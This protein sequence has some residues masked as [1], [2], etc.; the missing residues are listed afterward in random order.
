M[1]VIVL[2]VYDSLS[3]YY[4]DSEIS[5]FED[6]CGPFLCLFLF[7]FIVFTF[8]FLFNRL[9]ILFLYVVSVGEGVICHHLY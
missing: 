6:E 3:F 1:T 7:V 4:K 5:S 9:S 8:Y 2:S